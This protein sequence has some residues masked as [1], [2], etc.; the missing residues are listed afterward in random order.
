MELGLAPSA[1]A[2]VVTLWEKQDLG[3]VK[4]LFA[5]I[6]PSHEALALRMTPEK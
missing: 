1:A 6:V 5:A 3:Q 2:R 4:G